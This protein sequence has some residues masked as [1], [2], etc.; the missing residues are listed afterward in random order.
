MSSRGLS[1]PYRPCVGIMLVNHEGLAFIGRRVSGPEHADETHAWQMPQGGID[2]GENP[3]EAARREL[4]EETNIRSV[5]VIGETRDWLTYDLPSELV[6]V[7][8]KGRYRGQK[9]KWFAFRFTGEDR[10]IDIARPGD[11]RHHPE[12]VAWRW[13]EISRLPDLIVP[14]KRNAYEQI[15]A[16]LGPQAGAAV[17]S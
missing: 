14:F 5:E 3:L 16:E 13:E 15:V 8:W 6:G 12:F 9:Q 11:G 2:E 17:A 7:A 1:L 4:W 10:E